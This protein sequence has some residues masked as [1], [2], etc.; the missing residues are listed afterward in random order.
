[1]KDL[2]KYVKQEPQKVA[3]VLLLTAIASFLRVLHALINVNIFNELIK[4]NMGAFFKWVIYDLTV[5]IVLSVFW[6]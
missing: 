2:L 3:L 5:F 1:M 4:L 6:F